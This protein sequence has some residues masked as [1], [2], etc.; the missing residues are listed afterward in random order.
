MSFRHCPEFMK[1]IYQD[2]R[3]RGDSRLNSM[4]T[5]MWFIVNGEF[6]RIVLKRS[7]SERL[8]KALEREKKRN[9]IK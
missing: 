7:Y 1:I 2:K 9:N 3:K 6:Q 8:L 5:G 4:L